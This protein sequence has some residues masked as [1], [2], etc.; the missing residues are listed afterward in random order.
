MKLSNTNGQASLPSGRVGQVKVDV[1][2]VCATVN[3]VRIGAVIRGDMIFV[4]FGDVDHFCEDEA[5]D[6]S[7]TKAIEA[8]VMALADACKD[9]LG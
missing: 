6:R 1:L 3:G 5:V 2:D 4:R 9:C 8:A 7:R